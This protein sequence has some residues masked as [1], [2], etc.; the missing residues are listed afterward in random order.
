MRKNNFKKRNIKKR[1]E[2]SE[3]KFFYKDDIF[4]SRMSSILKIPHHKTKS[5]FYQRILSVIRLNDL[6]ADPERT[7]NLLKNR[8]LSL[9]KVDWNKH[10][11][12][13]KNMDKSELSKMEEHKQNLFYIQ[14][15]SSMIP[16]I[17][18]EP[19]SDDYILDMCSAPGSNTTQLASLMNNKGEIVANDNNHERTIK[20]QRI[21]RKFNVENTVVHFGNGEDLYKDFSDSFNKVLLNAPSSAEGLIYLNKKQPLK[22]WSIRKSQEISKVQ[23][24]L[25]ISAFKCLK[26]GGTMTYSTCT[27]SPNENESVVTYLLKNEDSASIENIDLIEKEEFF[28][29]KTFVQRGLKEWNNEIFHS[30]INKTIRIIPGKTMIGFYVALI[31]KN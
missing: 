9:N 11:Y 31:K 3:K 26:K 21:L 24:K 10:T 27:L 17:I 29:Y 1:N 30:D 13:V 8:N 2:S 25:I 16:A 22:F 14:N 20:M 6:I 12:I 5:L 7:L 18:L 4:I 23:K 28:N 15:L 19:K